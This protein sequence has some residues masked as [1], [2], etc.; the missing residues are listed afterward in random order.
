MVGVRIIFSRAFRAWGLKNVGHGGL[1]PHCN[2]FPL[3]DSC[4]SI[5]ECRFVDAEKDLVLEMCTYPFCRSFSCIV[6][7]VSRSIQMMYPLFGNVDFFL[8]RKNTLF[9]DD[10]A[11]EEMRETEYM[12]EPDSMLSCVLFVCCS[13]YLV[14]RHLR[15]RTTMSLQSCVRT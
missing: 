1:L 9:F 11:R 2:G 7:R 13:Q 8:T 15:C 12:R 6:F 4:W 10:S 3:R 14:T 5:F